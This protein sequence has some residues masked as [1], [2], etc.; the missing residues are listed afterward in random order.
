MHPSRTAPARPRRPTWLEAGAERRPWHGRQHLLLVVHGCSLVADHARWVVRRDEERVDVPGRDRKPEVVADEAPPARDAV[1]GARLLRQPV[2][3]L[4]G[5][6]WIPREVRDPDIAADR[7]GAAA[8]VLEGLERRVDAQIR[9]PGVAVPDAR[10]VRTGQAA[11]VE[12]N[13][14]GAVGPGATRRWDLAVGSGA[15]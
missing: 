8:A 4:Q 13:P 14:H 2:D 9:R 12:G 1:P 5:L 10:V 11:V 3:R 6:R 15:L 7:D